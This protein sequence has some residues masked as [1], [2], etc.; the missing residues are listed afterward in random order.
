MV[1]EKDIKAALKALKLKLIGVL[2]DPVTGEPCIYETATKFCAVTVE[3]EK[4]YSNKE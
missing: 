1:N 3:G 2:V 4:V